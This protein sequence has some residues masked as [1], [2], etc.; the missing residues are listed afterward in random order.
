VPINHL[1]NDNGQDEVSDKTKQATRQPE[2][3]RTNVQQTYLFNREREREIVRDI[4]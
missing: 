1:E 2:T 4:Q 3:R